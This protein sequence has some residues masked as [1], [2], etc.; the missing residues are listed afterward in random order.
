MFGKPITNLYKTY[1]LNVINRGR[2]IRPCGTQLVVLFDCPAGAGVDDA[3]G[4]KDEARG[5]NTGIKPFTTEFGTLNSPALA[6]LLNNLPSARNLN[7]HIV[8][9]S[10]LRPPQGPN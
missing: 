8:V 9:M 4:G 10:T 2:D 5:E 6:G 1:G 7:V 3:E